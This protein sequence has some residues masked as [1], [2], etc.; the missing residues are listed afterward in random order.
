[1]ELLLIRHAQ[2]TNNASMI[3]NP[4]DRVYDPPLTDLGHEQ[5]RALA[6]HLCEGY[7]AEAIT[8]ALGRRDPNARRKRGFRIDR[9]YCS[10]MHRSLLTARYIHETTGLKPRVWVDIHEHGGVYQQFDDERGIVGFPGRTR[11]EILDEFPTYDVSEQITDQGWWT[12]AME[13]IT[14]AYGRAIRVAQFFHALAE[15]EP[16][17]RVAIVSHGTFMDALLKALLNQLPS[18]RIWYYH[19]NTAITRVDLH[20]SYSAVRYINRVDHLTSEQI[21]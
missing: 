16:D 15:D 14:A 8:D 1:M 17:L 5:A 21:S 13:D 7:N 19:H 11:Q 4:Q 20:D 6:R 3:L 18:E 2:S 12:G 10:P 9:L